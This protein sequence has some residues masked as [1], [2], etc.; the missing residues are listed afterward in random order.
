MNNIYKKLVNDYYEGNFHNYRDK[1]RVIDEGNGSYPIYIDNY[2]CGCFRVL[3]NFD[4]TKCDLTLFLYDDK[5]NRQFKNK[6]ANYCYN[7]NIIVIY[8][9][10]NNE[11][12]VF[13]DTTNQNY[14]REYIKINALNTLLSYYKICNDENLLLAVGDDATYVIMSKDT[15]LNKADIL[16]IITNELV[17]IIDL[18]KFTDYTTEYID[19]AKNLYYYIPVK[20]YDYITTSVKLPINNKLYNKISKINVHISYYIMKLKAQE[21][22]YKNL[23]KRSK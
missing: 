6:L 8:C 20:S 17:D 12:D 1:Y 5:I 7:H 19:S 22:F 15:E 10:N 4:N 13:C 3:D 23:R 2:D 9:H 14:N 18:Y 11:N 21:I 16:K